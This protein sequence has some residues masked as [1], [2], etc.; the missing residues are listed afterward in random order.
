MAIGVDCPCGKSLSNFLDAVPFLADFLP[1]QHA[2]AYCGAV[3]DAIR[4]HPGEP[5]LAASFAMDA[6]VGLFRHLWQCPACGRLLVLGPDGTYHAF[7]P[8]RTDTP[9]DVLAGTPHQT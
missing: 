8:E 9:R 5:E 1:E 4:D 2:N 6:S 7:V 3:E